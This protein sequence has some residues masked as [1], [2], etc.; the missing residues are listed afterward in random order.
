MMCNAL[1]QQI[2][3]Q[4]VAKD[5]NDNKATIVEKSWTRLYPDYTHPDN[6]GAAKSITT[7]Q[8]K[9][10]RRHCPA[11]WASYYSSKS[12][13]IGTVAEM[14][15]SDDLGRPHGV[16]RTGHTDNQNA[17]DNYAQVPLSVVAKAGRVLAGWSFPK[18]P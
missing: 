7:V 9:H 18:Q 14:E 17:Y 8:T 5:A 2:D 12:P 6:P 16:A 10:I 13:K 3:N 11:Q 15:M 1:A 4:A